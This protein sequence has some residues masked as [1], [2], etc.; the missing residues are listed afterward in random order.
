[1]K[2]VWESKDGS[3]TRKITLTIEKTTLEDKLRFLGSVVIVAFVYYFFFRQSQKG[4]SFGC[5]T[6]P[7]GE[8]SPTGF[9]TCKK[10]KSEL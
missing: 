9:F 3:K 1:M 7:V 6:N 4:R 8:K 2:K 10:E 5:S